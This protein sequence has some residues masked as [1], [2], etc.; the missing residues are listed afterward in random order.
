MFPCRNICNFSYEGQPVLAMFACQ[1]L[2]SRQF[3]V[4]SRPSPVWGHVQTYYVL[5]ILTNPVY[6]LHPKQVCSYEQNRSTDHT[7]DCRARQLGVQHDKV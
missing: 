6:H 7:D 2:F 4:L 5:Q 1:Y 3:R